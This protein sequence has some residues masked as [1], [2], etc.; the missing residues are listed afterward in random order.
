MD[1]PTLGGR[2]KYDKQAS[3]ED[4]RVEREAH[5]SHLKFAEAD[6]HAWSEEVG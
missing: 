1:H 3:T 5:L 6:Q 4:G 2:K